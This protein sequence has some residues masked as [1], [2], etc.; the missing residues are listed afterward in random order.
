MM[1]SEVNT[2]DTFTA[3]GPQPAFLLSPGPIKVLLCQAWK[4]EGGN[5]SQEALTVARPMLGDSLV[6][7]G[8][9]P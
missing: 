5:C 1:T 3:Q 7:L 6:A 4:P 2:P 8:I 9:M